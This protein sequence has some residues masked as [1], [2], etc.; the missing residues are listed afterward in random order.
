MSLSDAIQIVLTDPAVADMVET[1]TAAIWLAIAAFVAGSEV[2]K[3]W[4][5]W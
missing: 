5:V 2:L 1:L 4:R 3:T